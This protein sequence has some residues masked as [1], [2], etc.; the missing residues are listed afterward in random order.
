MNRYTLATIAVLVMLMFSGCAEREETSAASSALSVE[1]EPF[2]VVRGDSAT[3]YTLTNANGMVVRA[4]DY[5]GIITSLLVPD[6]EGNLEDVAL[7]FDDVEGYLSDEYL[8]SNPYFGAIIGRYG[9]R[10]GD[11]QFT[12]DGETYEVTPNTPPHHLHGGQQ[13]FDK[14]MWEARPFEGPD[15]VGIVFTYTSPAGEEGYPGTLQ[16]E[17]TYT[18]NN[19]NELA[20]EYR[21]TTDEATPVNL[22]QHSYFNLAGEGD[23]DI[24]SHELMI[25]A[26]AFTPVDEELIPTGEIQPVADTPLDFRNFTSIGARIGAEDE[27]LQRGGGYDHNFVLNRE[28]SVPDDSLILAARVWE[29]ETGRL[30]E[31]HTTEPGIQF[32]SGNFLDGTLTEADG[33]AFEYRSGFALETQHYPDSPNQ[34]NFPSTILRPGEEYHSRTVYTFS[35]REELDQAS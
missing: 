27:Q 17:V 30:L 26:D 32:Y 4:T 1:Q 19:D 8:A 31:I 12:L 3:L 13:G 21:A 10:I 35:T 33:D 22:T 25:N 24:L 2:G 28:E 15:S 6:T 7:G 5:G 14:V 18:L 29:P 23:G 9:N 20:F 34:P 11:S 16:A